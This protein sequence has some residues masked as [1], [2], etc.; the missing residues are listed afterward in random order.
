I[1]TLTLR[2]G[3]QAVFNLVRWILT[4]CYL[5]MAIAGAFWLSAAP[6]LLL[7][8]THLLALGLL[9]WHSLSV[10]LTHKAAITRFY[11]FIW[12]LFFWEYLIFP[13]AWLVG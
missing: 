6:P 5:G 3:P 8:S 12:K 2:L 10:D 7:I 1:S 13:A 4:A 11:Q 9:W